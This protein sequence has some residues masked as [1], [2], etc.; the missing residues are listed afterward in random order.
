MVRRGAKRVPSARDDEAYDGNKLFKIPS[1][2]VLP[3]RISPI[4][5]FSRRELGKLW[6]NGSRIMENEF[7][8]GETEEFE[9]IPGRPSTGD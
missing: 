2:R 7:D 4:I 8:L 5:F 3:E 9:D 1:T 6:I